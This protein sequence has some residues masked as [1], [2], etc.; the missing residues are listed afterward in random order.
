MSVRIGSYTAPSRPIKRGSPQGSVLGSQ[1]Y[2][3]T[4]QLLT[5]RLRD[6]APQPPLSAQREEDRGGG[7]NTAVGNP[8]KPLVFMY[9]DDTTLFDAA[10]TDKAVK[11]LSLGM[12]PEEIPGLSPPGRLPRAGKKGRGHWHDN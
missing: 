3:A 11:H 4:T 10:E 9:V 8:D 1:L 6:G 2:C 5:C 7:D 12:P